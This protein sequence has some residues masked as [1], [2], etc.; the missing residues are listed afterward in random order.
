MRPLIY[1]AALALF[2]S[3]PAVDGA[4]LRTWS[5]ESGKFKREETRLVDVEKNGAGVVIKVMLVKGTSKMTVWLRT[6]CQ[7]DRDYVETIYPSGP[8]AGYRNR[9]RSK[10]RTWT[11]ANGDFQLEYAKMVNVV[12]DR[13]RA[14]VKVIIERDGIQLPIAI[15]NLSQEDQDYVDGRY[16]R[17]PS[18]STPK[19]TEPE[20]SAEP[21][22]PFGPDSSDD[23]DDP[24]GPDSSD[25]DDDPFGSD[26]SDDGDDPFG[27]NS[28]DDDDDPFGSD[29]SD[30]GDDPFGS[31][32]SD[33]T[34]SSTD[35]PSQQTVSTIGDMPDHAAIL[36]PP[37]SSKK[38]INLS[39]PLTPQT[40]ANKAIVLVCIDTSQ[41]KRVS[42]NLW[43]RRL[44]STKSLLNKPVIFI[45]VLPKLTNAHAKAYL[46]VL[47]KEKVNLDWPILVDEN[48]KFSAA[49]GGGNSTSWGIRGID[50][51]GHLFGEEL[52]SN[53]ATAAGKLLNAAKFRVDPS[54]IPSSLKKAWFKMEYGQF[55][56]AA[57]KI[58]KGLES[59]DTNQ[60]AFAS[61]LNA[62]AQETIAKHVGQADAALT[63]GNKAHA[64][65]Y[66][67]LVIR[68]FGGYELDKKILDTFA[69]LEQDKE[70]EAEIAAF[71]TL[72]KAM[73]LS[74]STSRANATKAVV[75]KFPDTTAAR[76][77][78]V[79]LERWKLK[80]RALAKSL[81]HKPYRGRFGGGG[82]PAE[83]FNPFA[84]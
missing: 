23:D 17:K 37:L 3:A 75:D 65:R 4:E 70:L 22:D 9:S 58:R 66:F 83:T 32:S 48:R 16:G 68:E 36:L 13:T 64:Y 80:T 54:G 15:N 12:R 56:L 29:S 21:D 14:I 45:A 38:W 57:K 43:S 31:D 74:R 8:A 18:D 84:E 62:H 5:S 1:F 50:G 42:A 53:P 41:T 69:K 26:S 47:S 25:D 19:P 76:D 72:D 81:S 44:I 82:D 39:V 20:S 30:D 59:E 67:D 6:L 11:S 49:I 27:A 33:E 10:W 28:S 73:K 51:N 55:R 78:V 60:K 63:A 61:R 24:F 34:E 2:L 71:E 46:S 77:A 35:N 7:A 79:L 52:G 40:V